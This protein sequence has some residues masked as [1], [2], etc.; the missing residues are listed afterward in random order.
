MEAAGGEGPEKGAV[1]GSAAVGS[2]ISNL[3][4]VLKEAHA[5]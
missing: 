2:S 3:A 1:A 4:T 5:K